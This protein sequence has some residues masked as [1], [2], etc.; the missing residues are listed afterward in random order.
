MTTSHQGSALASLV[1]GDRV[2]GRLY[3]DTLQL[4]RKLFGSAVVVLC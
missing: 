1:S 2:A 3:T 4:P